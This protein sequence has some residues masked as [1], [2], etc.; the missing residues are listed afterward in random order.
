MKGLR[1][2]ASAGMDIDFGDPLYHDSIDHLTDP[3]VTMMEGEAAEKV[4]ALLSVPLQARATI[5]CVRPR[6]VFEELA[7][8]NLHGYD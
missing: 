5:T 2:K 4:R 8:A 3:D 7:T 6:S 1:S